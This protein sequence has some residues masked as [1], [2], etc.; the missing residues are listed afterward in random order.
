MA[1]FNEIVNLWKSDD[2]LSQAWS[3]SYDMIN[4]SNRIFEKAVFYLRNGGEKT[5]IKALKK[6][7]QEI[8]N[9]QMAVRKKVI[10]HFS[11]SNDLNHLPNGLVLLNIV[12]DIERVGDYTK[13][14]LDL[15]LNHSKKILSENISQD[16]HDIE[17]EVIDRFNKTIKALDNQDQTSAIKLLKTYKDS[18]ATKSDLIVNNCISGKSSFEN[19]SKTTSI[20]LYARYLKR[21]GAHLKNITTTIVNPFEYIGYKP[22]A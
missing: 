19:D 14:I 11:I 17:N 15:S 16:L 4:L 12:I 6:R 9:F 13:N 5:E 20:A 3:E 21:V 2:L 1:I 22:R 8:N 7:D 18:L 10:T